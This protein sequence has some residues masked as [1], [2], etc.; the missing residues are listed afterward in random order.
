M[1]ER[2]MVP[3]DGSALAERALPCARRL[4][5]ATGATLHLVRVVEPPAALTPTGLYAPI[6]VYGELMDAE[7]R[8]EAAYL[9][10]MREHMGVG[11]ERVPVHLERLDGD[12][13]VALRNYERA[14]GIDLVVLCSHGRGGLAR[15]A[16]GSVAERLLRHGLAPVLLVR[17]YG[18]PVA[19]ARIVLPLDGSPGAEAALR[20]AA[21]LSRAVVREVTLVRVIDTPTEGPEAERYLVAAA[22]RL[23]RA[24]LIRGG[25]GGCRCQVRQGDP[26]RAIIDAAGTDRLVVMATRGRTGV[27]R[28]AL[29]SVADRVARGGAAAVLLVRAGARGATEATGVTGAT[30]REEMERCRA[31]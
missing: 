28:L 10:R 2:I 20:A 31:R 24:G 30:D 1:F 4:A 17:A 22:R 3:L 8:E 9:E 12:A 14:A 23:Q 26:A 16:L 5:A 15:F 21:Q 25:E 6:N 27:S 18:P 11:A 29:G 7:R 13:A 19:L